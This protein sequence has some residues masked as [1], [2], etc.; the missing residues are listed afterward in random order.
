MKNALTLILALSIFSSFSQE[1]HIISNLETKLNIV[2]YSPEI[3]ETVILLHG[4][5]G[6][7]EPMTE[8]VSLL[9]DKYRVVTFDQRGTG[10]SNCKKCDYS[11]ESYISDIDTIAAFLGIRKFHLFGHSWGG[12]YAQIYAEENPDKL[13]S[14]FLSS[15]SSGTN[16]LWK[17]TEK[18]VMKYNKSKSSGA[19]WTKMGWFSI[20]G[21]LGSDKAYQ[22]MFAMVLK[23]YTGVETDSSTTEI[24]KKVKSAPVNKTRKEI[25][26]YHELKKMESHNFPIIITYGADDIYGD[27]Y[28]YV[29]ERYPNAQKKIIQD[30]GHIPWESNYSDYKEI[31]I[32]F[33]KLN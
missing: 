6:V 9:K 2:V 16:D 14:L 5:P 29:Y 17:L 19:E 23:N 28:L 8:V 15:P 33:Y 11:M 18:N 1:N 25:I 12:L 27:S 22:K 32:E 10:Y 3:D 21:K 26:K 31:L 7:P 4:G 20:L 24:L 13:L 30:S